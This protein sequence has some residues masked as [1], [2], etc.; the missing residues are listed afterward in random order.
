MNVKDPKAQVTSISCTRVSLIL[1]LRGGKE[2]G[3]SDRVS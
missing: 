1:A 2:V 3:V